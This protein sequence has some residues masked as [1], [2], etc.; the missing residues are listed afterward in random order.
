[1]AQDDRLPFVTGTSYDGEQITWD[2]LSEAAG[3]NIFFEFQYI[4]TVIGTS[5]IPQATGEYRISAFD[6][7]G[8]FS[9]LQLIDAGV[10]PTSNFAIV[11]TLPG[12]IDT[13]SDDDN[14]GSS[15]L[16]PDQLPAVSGVVSDGST[17][18]WEP[19]DG[20]S[21]YNIYLDNLYLDTVEN[22]TSYEP[23]GSG[24]FSVAAFDNLG[25]FSPLFEVDAN[26][27]QLEFTNFVVIN[28][29]APD[30]AD[31][32]APTAPQNLR[33]EIYGPRVAELFWDRPSSSE[34]IVETEVFRDGVLIG[35]TSGISFFDDNRASGVRHE[36]QLVAINVAGERSDSTFTNAS[37]FVG[38]AE[39]VAQT[40]LTGLSSVIN[41]NPHVRFFPLFQDFAENGLPGD[42]SLISEDV[43]EDP[44]I[45]EFFVEEYE[46]DFGG[47]AIITRTDAVFGRVEFSFNDCNIDGSIYE[48]QVII[49]NGESGGYLADYSISLLANSDVQ[50]DGTV[51]LTISPDTGTTTL[52]YT[53]FSFFEL[54]F[55]DS[56][57]DGADDEEVAAELNQVIRS[58]LSETPG[59]SYTTELTVIGPFTNNRTFEVTTLA[60]FTGADQG[61]GNYLQGELTVVQLDEN[62]RDD[63]LVLN[64]DTGVATTWQATLTQDGEVN[65]ISDEWNDSLRLPCIAAPGNEAATP[66]CL[67]F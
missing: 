11:D 31:I 36:Y 40:L 51:E 48:G 57:F 60:P 63:S 1:M 32:P 54:T 2:A 41:N 19:V 64:A 8:R 18:T 30:F 24:R 46:C 37:P 38:P 42:L 16:D 15:P 17:I 12:A 5:F 43:F 14:A 53:D 62:A 23:T 6:R 47:I 59:S 20:A 3:Y 21:G 61:S 56:S 4:D 27:T 26:G 33:V 55:D 67:S 52:T 29:T 45:G 10:V 7:M 28:E 58:S 34:Q 25:R 65:T 35:A 9:P 13:G 50:M 49:T 39:E 66:G 22:S 44:G